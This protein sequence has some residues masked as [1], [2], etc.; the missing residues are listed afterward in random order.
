MRYNQQVDKVEHCDGKSWVTH[1]LITP[2]SSY[3]LPALS[4]KEIAFYH[5]SSAKNGKY[6]IKPVY[7]DLPYQVKTIE[8]FQ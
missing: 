2:G 6:W 5:K 1:L 3:L 7:E 4:C 8:L